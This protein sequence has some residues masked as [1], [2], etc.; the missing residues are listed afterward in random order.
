MS[1][2][3][4][5]E[6]PRMHPDTTFAV[7]AALFNCPCSTERFWKKWWEPKKRAWLHA[8]AATSI[9][10]RG[11]PW[12]KEQKSDVIFA[13]LDSSLDR[14]VSGAFPLRLV[15]LVDSASEE[16]SNDSAWKARKRP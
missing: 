3:S 5:G 16:Q 4:T 14:S 10:W 13:H 11:K 9:W 12:A 2:C 1:G 8:H 7:P 15:R 6:S